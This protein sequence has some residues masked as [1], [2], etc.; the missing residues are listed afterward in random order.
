MLHLSST[1]L[2]RMT[3]TPEWSAGELKISHSGEGNGIHKYAKLYSLQTF[4]QP[5]VI[6]GSLRAPCR[7]LGKIVATVLTLLCLSYA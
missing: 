2:P 7:E 5:S 1:S 4:T 3:T 6:D